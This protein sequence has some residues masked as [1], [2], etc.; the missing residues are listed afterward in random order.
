MP[1]YRRVFTAVAL[2]AGCLTAGNFAAS[3]L[4][5]AGMFQSATAFAVWAAFLI[6]IGAC[7]CGY[8]AFR[9]P[10]LWILWPLLFGA[11]MFVFGFAA[12]FDPPDPR[13]VLLW[14]ALGIAF[15]A[16]PMGIAFYGSKKAVKPTAT[17]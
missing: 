1:Q 9:R 15:V 7:L 3:L 8:I 16:A 2:A 13:G 4:I 12:G 14:R 11:P 10:R 6:A 17:A 5:G